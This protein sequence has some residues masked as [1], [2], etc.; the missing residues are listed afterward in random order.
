MTSNWATH[1]RSY[2]RREE[3]AHVATSV[4]GV[5]ASAAAILWWALTWSLYPDTRPDPWRL[6]GGAVFCTTALLMFLSSALYHAARAPRLKAALR[7]LD[8]SSIY[9]LIAGTYTPFA[10]G[11]LRGYLGWGLFGSIWTMALFG[12]IVKQLGGLRVPAISIAVYVVMGWAGVLVI[13]QLAA[14]LTATQFHWMLAGGGIYTCG[15]PFYAYKSR[16]FTHTMWHLFVLLGVGCHF[17]AVL[18]LMR[19]P[20]M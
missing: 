10:L 11:V 17:M 18:S 14:H 15:V 20:T 3:A 4:L 5:V 12:I 2:S 6:F 7:T 1:T 13:K 8:H 16:P 9:L 19:T